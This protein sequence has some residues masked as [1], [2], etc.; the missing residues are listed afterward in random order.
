[1]ESLYRFNAKFA[2]LWEPRFAIF[3]GI[4]NLARV[5]YAILKIEAFIPEF[6]IKKLEE[7]VGN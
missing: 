6:R 3:P 1:M 5:G 2:P 4:R 7:R